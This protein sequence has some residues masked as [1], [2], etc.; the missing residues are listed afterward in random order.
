LAGATLKLHEPSN[1]PT[2]ELDLSDEPVEPSTL[3]ESGF[4]VG[5]HSI[6]QGVRFLLF[7]T[8]SL[9]AFGFILAAGG[10][11][12]A[13]LI[14]FPLVELPMLYKK[15]TRHWQEFNSFSGNFFNRMW[16]FIKGLWE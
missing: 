2:G 12:F 6:G 4:S 5:I 3:P 9:L 11:Y 1:L 13:A 7:V 14:L 15:A 10:L 8:L 16:G